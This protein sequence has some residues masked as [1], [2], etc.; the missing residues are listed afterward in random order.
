MSW[1]EFREVLQKGIQ[2]LDSLRGPALG[3]IL[4]TIFDVGIHG[5]VR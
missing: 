5:P 3:V 2:W 1:D 4:F